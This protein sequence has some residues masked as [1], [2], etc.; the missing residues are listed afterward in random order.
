MSSNLE[1]F[2][3]VVSTIVGIG[4]S[5]IVYGI[6]KN[7]VPTETPIDKVTVVAGSFVIGS[8]AADA[9]KK[10]TDKMI[11]ETIDWYKTMKTMLN[12]ED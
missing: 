7:N 1:M 8:M 5:K 2:K 9:T 12:A 4:A 11:D 10:H 3:S 6:V